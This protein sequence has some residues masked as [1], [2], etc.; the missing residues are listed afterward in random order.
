MKVVAAD[1]A[2][3][4]TWSPGWVLPVILLKI[5]M[6][7]GVGPVW[8]PD[9]GYYARTADAIV[10]DS[11]WLH[12]ADYDANYV[13]GLTFRVL[14]YPVVLAG[15][16]AFFGED[17]AWAV[18]VLQSLLSIGLF[19][20]LLRITPACLRFAG[21]SALITVL[22]MLSPM[23]VFDIS[24]LSDSLTVVLVTGAMLI[25]LGGVVGAWNLGPGPA[26]AAGGAW[27]L[28][29]MIRDAGLYFVVL[30][31]V[32]IGLW[33]VAARAETGR[34]VVLALCV[35]APVLLVAEGYKSWTEHRTGERFLSNTGTKNWLRPVFELKARGYADPFAGDDLVDRAVRR[36]D[37]PLSWP[38]NLAVLPEIQEQA[39]LTPHRL[40]ERVRAKFMDTV[41]AH[42]LAYTALVA[43]QKYQLG[44]TAFIA[45]DP[46]YQ[47]D[48]LF[49]FT[50]GYDH[51][52]IPASRDLHARVGAGE[53]GAAALIVLRF[54]FQ[55]TAIV[56]LL[57]FFG[58]GLVFLWRLIRGRTADRPAETAIVL[59][60]TFFFAWSVGF[61]LVHREDRHLLPVLPFAWLGLLMILERGIPEALR[62]RR[63]RSARR[64][65]S[66]ASSSR[67][68]TRW[69][70]RP[71]WKISRRRS[72]A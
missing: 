6:V 60:W 15:A 65:A 49:L 36:V 12:E 67:V 50:S 40:Q 20:L 25:V 43:T 57:V 64:G 28:S 19:L 23:T 17:Y 54:V 46:I 24:I 69:R 51:R 71:N 47:L 22:Y 56:L 29:V 68:S 42:P 72:S 16:K 18:I 5:A 30:P 2:H 11:A 34:A 66:P 39:G 61:A 26:L 55:L 52:F 59:C 44:D 32:G 1:T 33:A 35:L 62:L 13:G 4:R 53:I 37:P 63:R 21:A 70:A 58:G 9:T 31:L 7:I 14:G 27:A 10:G 3:R 41:L 8:W 45:F 48:Y 38:E